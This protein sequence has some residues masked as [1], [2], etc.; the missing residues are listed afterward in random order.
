MRNNIQM[1]EATV[2]GFLL[3]FAGGFLDAY[4]YI[5]RGGVFA[6]AQ[7]GNIVLLGIHLSRGEWLTGLYYLIPILSFIVGI[8]MAECIKS[9]FQPESRLHWRQIILAIELVILM[10]V[11]F[12]PQSLD[13]VANILISFVCSLQV[14][15]FRKLN[16]LAYAT[17]MCTGN[18][19][20]ASELLYRCSVTKDK[21]T[22]RNSLK[23]YEVILVFIAGAA[24][25]AFLTQT[26]WEKAVWAACAVIFAVF[27]LM[28]FKTKNN[29]ND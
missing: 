10:G 15:S 16:G 3:A 8:V 23:Y 24:A 14:E 7:T 29:T 26:L 5:C 27:C 2:T 28:F 20:S 17:T 13:A 18:L 19:R 11:G 1:S 22:L 12:M 6:N 9:K 21:T 4:T 25:G